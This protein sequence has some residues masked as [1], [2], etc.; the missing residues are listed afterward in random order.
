VQIDL[1]EFDMFRLQNDDAYV[2]LQ[3]PITVDESIQ[4]IVIVGGFTIVVKNVIPNVFNGMAND[5]IDNVE[6]YTTTFNS[7][8]QSTFLS[9]S[10]CV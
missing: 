8:G 6:E 1:H 3:A 5:G 2:G 10:T 4:P 9:N 7:D